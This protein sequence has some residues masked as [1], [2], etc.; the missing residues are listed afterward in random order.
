MRAP[1]ST[2]RASGETIDQ[3]VALAGRHHGVTLSEPGE[4]C[5]PSRPAR[6][7][8]SES[9]AHAR[10][11]PHRQRR[12]SRQRPLGAP[13]RGAG[14]TAAPGSARKLPHAAATARMRADREPGPSHER[15]HKSRDGVMVAALSKRVFL[16][17][18]RYGSPPRRVWARRSPRPR[19]LSGPEDPALA[20]H[21]R[22]AEV[23]SQGIKQVTLAGKRVYWAFGGRLILQNGRGLRPGIACRSAAS[24]DPPGGQETT[25]L[26]RLRRQ[27]RNDVLVLPSPAIRRSSS[28]PPSSAA[29]CPKLRITTRG[30][31]WALYDSY[32]IFSADSDGKEPGPPHGHEGVRRGGTVCEGRS[33][34]SSLPRRRHR[35]LSDGRMERTSSRLTNTPGY[36]GGAF[37][38]AD[39][40]K[41][42]SGARRVRSRARTST[43]IRGS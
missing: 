43:T 20:R 24:S 6:S 10:W 18:G 40:S 25:A 35:P 5:P 12:R 30:Y 29:K 19:S 11:H 36:D 22:P 27:G 38:N 3:V 39:C 4:S 23:P 9:P 33:I 31:V 17:S 2:A 15:S 26:P 32:D 14:L 37:F 8:E 1:A 21:P 7:D 42:S 28:R 13:V 34:V 41:R 16:G